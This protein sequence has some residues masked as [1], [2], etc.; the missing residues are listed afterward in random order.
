[1]T[2]LGRMLRILGICL[3]FCV[4]FIQWTVY[5]PQAARIIG[6]TSRAAGQEKKTGEV[7]EIVLTAEEDCR[8]AVL[9]SGVQKAVFSG[10]EA[11]IMVG[12]YDVVE[13]LPL[14]GQK[15]HVT[16][17]RVDMCLPSSLLNMSIECQARKSFF[18][19]R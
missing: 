18:R 10:G 2:L 9:V 4:L 6:A 17:S 16:V 5:F 14:R 1:M 7:G 15:C 11:K 12:R 19:I 13:I 3:L 8:A